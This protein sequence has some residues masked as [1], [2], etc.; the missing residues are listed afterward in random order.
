[1]STGRTQYIP[2]EVAKELLWWLLS[3]VV[4]AMI[5]LPLT[6]KLYF[7]PLWINGLFIVMALTYFRYSVLLKTT[8]VL[9]PVWVKF[10]LAVFNINFFVYVLRRLQE[11]MHIYDSFTIE[12]MGTPRRPLAPEEVDPLFRYFFE[13]INLACVACLTLSVVLIVRMIAVYWSGAKLRLNA[14][15]EE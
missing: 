3:A 4:A 10:L 5:M 14:G 9:R 1:M 13:E 8:F 6:S 7:K 15:G 11:F 12:A 2:L